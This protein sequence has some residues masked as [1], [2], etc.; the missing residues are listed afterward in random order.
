[1]HYRVRTAELTRLFCTSARFVRKHVECEEARIDFAWEPREPEVPVPEAGALSKKVAVSAQALLQH[2]RGVAFGAEATRA[3]LPDQAPLL[4]VRGP[5]LD[6][7]HGGD[8]TTGWLVYPLPP[9]VWRV[10]VRM[11]GGDDCG[12]T[13]VGLVAGGRVIARRCGKQD[14]RL[15]AATL[16]VPSELGPVSLVAVDMA[17]GRWGH[18]LLSDVELW[19]EPAGVQVGQ[20]N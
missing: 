3:A 7:F 10:T 16:E 11:G 13:F 5:V 2:A 19:S 18:V 20:A 14:E 12:K 8:E 9:E 6:S 1:M 17:T 15:R 4:D